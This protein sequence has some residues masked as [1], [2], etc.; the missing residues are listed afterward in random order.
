M[1]QLLKNRLAPFR[2]KSFRQFFFVQTLSLTGS[3][4]SDLARAWIILSNHGSAADLGGL[5]LASATPGLFLILHG[6]VLIDRVDVKK[7]MIWTKTLLGLIVLGLAALVELSHIEYWHLL[8]FGFLDGL[9]TAFDAPAYQA[10][11]VRLVPRQDFQQA[12]AL[13]STNFHMSRMLGPF[14]AGILMAWHGPSLVFLFDGITFLILAFM[15]AGIQLVPIREMKKV[16]QSQWQALYDGIKYI[17]QSPLRY[18]VM[19][20]LLT[21]SFMFPLMLVV[22]RTYIQKK[23]SLNAEQFGYTFTL[24]ALGSMAG[25][26]SF[27]LIQPKKP[28][29]TL[30]IG[31]PGATLAMILVPFAPSASL[32]AV[33]MAF[34]GFFMYLTFASLTV[35]IQLE[36]QEEFRGRLSSVIG[37]CFVS[38]G[39]LM[40]FPIGFVADTMGYTLSIEIITV[41]FLALS[42]VLW[43]KKN[44]NPT[45]SLSIPSL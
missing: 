35:S 6:G 29:K 17:V 33:D 24:P 5:L 34:A 16:M 30:L 36:V 31:I 13:N 4:A 43:Y 23:F 37:L 14:I 10:L 40:G 25:A 19:Q 3:W 9:V 39:P 15:I 41:G 44:Q 11:T 45:N 20:L 26:L 2:H 42:S 8:I 28:L 12:L 32:A 38:I 1:K 27:T 7:V 18:V 21:I 22:F